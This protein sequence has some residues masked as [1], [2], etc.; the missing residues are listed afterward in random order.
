MTALPRHPPLAPHWID[1]PHQALHWDEF[2]L[3]SGA[4]IQN[5]EL[6]YVVHGELNA[7]RDNLVIALPAVGSTHHRLDFLIG[8]GRALNPEHHCVVCFDAWGNGLASSP[9]NS[10][11]QPG[12]QFPRFTIRDMVNAQ[13]ALLDEWQVPQ[14]ACVIGASMGG[15]QALQWAVSHPTRT[16]RVVAM[17]PMART[18]PW[19]RSVNEVSRLILQVGPNQVAPLD[20]Q[21]W[22]AW[23]GLM[24]CLIGQTPQAFD[25]QF[26]TGEDAIDFLQQKAQAQLH[27]HSDPI[28]W[29]YQSQA[30]DLHDL[31]TTPGVT[32]GTDNALAGITA[33]CLILGPDLD[34]Y[35]PASAWRHI[36]KRI[37]GALGVEIPSMLGHQSASGVSA[38]DSEFLNR[39]ILAWLHRQRGHRDQAVSGNTNSRCTANGVVTVSRKNGF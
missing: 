11:H 28:D 37:P 21:R 39:T 34:L 38:A 20:P 10:L 6:T 1:R 12:W 33:E 35:N 30:Y 19:A 32:G 31:G 8:P 24:Q 23:S 16:Q 7:R 5:A 18:T 17:T 14:A 15:M 27:S 3:E 2:A 25:S 26:D 9:S 22:R 13:C 4:S 36:A 29:W